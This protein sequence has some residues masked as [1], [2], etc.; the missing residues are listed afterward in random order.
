MN[1]WPFRQWI[2]AMNAL[3]A[4]GRPMQTIHSELTCTLSLHQ[5]MPASIALKLFFFFSSR[6]KSFLVYSP[7]IKSS[8]AIYFCQR[9]QQRE[10][11][12]SKAINKTA[13]QRAWRRAKKSTHTHTNTKTGQRRVP[14]YIYINIS[15]NNLS[16]DTSIWRL[17][18]GIQPRHQNDNNRNYY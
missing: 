11:Q 18:H 14:M 10:T 7:L 1:G 5:P 15:E 8:V 4:V 13:S 12:P 3:C 6:S 16:K 2:K 9:A 17:A